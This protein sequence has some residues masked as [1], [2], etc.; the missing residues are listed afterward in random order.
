MKAVGVPDLARHINGEIGL[1]E[2][3]ALAQQS[4]RR[5]AKR[6]TTW[7]R[8]QFPQARI[9]REQFSERIAREIF[10]FLRAFLLT[11]ALTRD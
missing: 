4:T 8:H 9:V 3:I 1:E 11:R 5:Y 10:S 2:A 7:F 6:Q